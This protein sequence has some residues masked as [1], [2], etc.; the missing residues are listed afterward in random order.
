MSS[1]LSRRGWL[2]RMG[3]PS[4]SSRTDSAS[5]AESRHI[6]QG[7]QEPCEAEAEAA[8]VSWNTY[9]SPG[10]RLIGEEGLLGI[11]TCPRPLGLRA[12]AF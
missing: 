5:R 9:C 11:G 8:V 7:S 3:A 10:C 12:M 2:Q 4:L 6:H 1:C